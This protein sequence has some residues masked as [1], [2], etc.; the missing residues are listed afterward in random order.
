MHQKSDQ[1]IY[2]ASLNVDLMKKNVIQINGGITI[3]VYVRVKNIMYMKKIIFGIL[4][5]AVAKME[6]I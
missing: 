6:N 4:L 2:H 5:H 3:N 1:K